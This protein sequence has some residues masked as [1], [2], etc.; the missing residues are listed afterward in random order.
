MRQATCRICL[1]PGGNSFC[2][3][4][5]TLAHVHEECLL[6]WLRVSKRKDC[7]ICKHTFEYNKTCKPKCTLTNQDF[8]LSDDSSVQCLLI[9]Y[10][11]AAT[12]AIFI[13]NLLLSSYTAGF[14]ASHALIL[15]MLAVTYKE[16]YTVT[17]LLFMQWVSTVGQC[18]FVFDVQAPTF[19]EAVR[20][21]NI[22]TMCLGASC[23]L[24]AVS[25]FYRHSC[26]A[27]SSIK[28]VYS[29]TINPLHDVDA[30]DCF[31]DAAERYGT[32]ESQAE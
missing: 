3:C 2:K 23:F 29:S 10:T 9:M 26:S 11:L 19:R 20:I 18:V 15:L 13:L 14:F 4:A 6:K 32:Q 8:T 31:G 1:E 30:G 5:G 22:Q 21:S 25:V 16:C 27:I 7:E 24:W 17:T 12:F 28:M